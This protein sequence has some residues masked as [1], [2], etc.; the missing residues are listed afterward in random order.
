MHEGWLGRDPSTVLDGDCHNSQDECLC[1]CVLRSIKQL[2]G[3]GVEMRQQ[4]GRNEGGGVRPARQTWNVCGTV[5][6]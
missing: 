1:V 6:I 2:A 4:L 3:V 5:Q